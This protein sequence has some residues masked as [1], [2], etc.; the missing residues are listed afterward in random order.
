MIKKK[1][2]LIE[3][4]E[5]MAELLRRFLVEQELEVSHVTRPSQAIALLELE[6]FDL[7]ILDLSLPEMDGLDLCI[8]IREITDI[9]IIISSARSDLADKL[10][11]FENGADD[12][13]PK[14]YSPRELLARIKSIFKRDSS[15]K[16]EKVLNSRFNVDEESTQI[17]FD[18]EVLKLTLAEYEI[19]KL[20]IKRSGQTVSREEIANSIDSH[21]FDSGVESIN[22]LIGRIRKKLDPNKFDTFIQTVR[23]IGYR[24]VEN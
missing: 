5:Q 7:I 20:L 18:K 14:P 8:K 22:I 10:I 24:F 23:G 1:I 4:D 3:D 2:L 16:A 17:S 13:L 6:K 15:V 12:Y 11:G 19:L 9:Y 21:R